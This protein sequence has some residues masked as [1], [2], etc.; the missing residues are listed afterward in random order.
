ML[1]PGQQVSEDFPRFGLP[2][3]ANRFPANTDAPS[4]TV[5][6][7]NGVDM[8]LENALHGLQRTTVTADF[9]CVTTWS[10][11]NNTWSGVRFRDF[12]EQHYLAKNQNS[13]A[14]K[15]VAFYAQDGYKTTLPLEDLLHDNVL[16]ADTLDDSALTI[17]H[18]A[19]LRLV[20]P[21]HYGYKNLKHLERIVFHI[22]SPQ[23]KRGIHKLL[24]HPRARVSREERGQIF[25]GWFLR[26]LYRPM[27]NSTRKSF[28]A[29]LDKFQQSQ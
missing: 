11:V 21:A 3:Y 4:V 16:L 23:L 19:P 29:A 10:H 7:P 26:I 9:H 20:A 28:Q 12:F 17:K 24:D 8:F 15:T 5:T 13:T 27:I 22:D 14:I 6:D 1:P 2:P 18:G 25:P